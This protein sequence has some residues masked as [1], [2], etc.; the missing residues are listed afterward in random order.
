MLHFLLFEAGA[1]LPG[2]D[3]VGRLLP[4]LGVDLEAEDSGSSSLVLEPS[5]SSPP[6]PPDGEGSSF[7]LAESP[8]LAERPEK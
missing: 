6:M 7:L 2:V 5:P 1:P 4:V 3:L 8:V